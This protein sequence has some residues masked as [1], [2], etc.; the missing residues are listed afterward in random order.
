MGITAENISEKFNIDIE[1]LKN[2]WN[3]KFEGVIKQSKT[4]SKNVYE[5]SSEKSSVIGDD[6]IKCIYKLIENSQYQI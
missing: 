6:E 2:I 1:E 4:T 3:S 5:K